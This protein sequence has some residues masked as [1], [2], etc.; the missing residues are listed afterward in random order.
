M[1]HEAVAA[2]QGGDVILVKEGFNFSFATSGKQL[3]LVAE[4]GA[5]V[6]INNTTSVGGLA[7]GQEV[8]LAGL[9]LGPAS[10]PLQLGGSE[11]PI[12]LH[13]CRVLGNPTGAFG[14]ADAA[15]VSD[16]V[17]VLFSDSRVEGEFFGGGN[18][19]LVERSDLHPWSTILRGGMPNQAIA[20]GG[21]GLRL[22]DG[23]LFASDCEIQ[24]GPGTDGFL[25]GPSCE[26]PNPRGYRLAK[27]LLRSGAASESVFEGPT[28]ELAGFAALGDLSP[29]Y[30][31][32][33]L[34]S[35]ISLN[36]LK[37]VPVDAIPAD[38]FLDMPISV[39]LPPGVVSHVFRTESVFFGPTD[40]LLLGPPAPA[41]VIDS[42][43]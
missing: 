34:A 25:A 28:G 33:G 10:L 8:L 7:L 41:I 30:F 20:D 36:A 38:G 15:Q 14:T 17:D 16:C 32:D 27:T 5:Y 3:T 23:F 18:A 24:G 9:Q 21:V 37:F 39:Q 40:G 1:V 31:S 13:D 12:W 42:P 11:G 29:S 4:N 22:E 43:L 19:C 2:A 35:A 26:G 6:A